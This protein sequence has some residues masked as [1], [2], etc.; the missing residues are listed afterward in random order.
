MS[1]R[2]VRERVRERTTTRGG[3]ARSFSWAWKAVAAAV[4]ATAV[5]LV[6]FRDRPAIRTAQDSPTAPASLAPTPNASPLRATMR[7]MEVKKPTRLPR[8]RHVDPEPAEIARHEKPASASVPGLSPEEADQLAR[9]VVY[10]SH[11]QG[12]PPVI[13][14]EERGHGG[15]VRS[16]HPLRNSKPERGH[17]LADRFKRRITI[18]A[19]RFDF[20][21][22]IPMTA[23]TSVTTARSSEGEH[24][25]PELQEARIRADLDIREGQY[26]VVGKTGLGGSDNALI[27]VLSA[28]VVD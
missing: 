10:V 24:A 2:S 20:H 21:V 4:V 1:L 6:L 13:E 23:R 14:A 18:R 15:Y 3:E 17:L 27:L 7:P 11:L 25:S 9:A 28:R 16:F 19:T 26:V 5:A 12:L 8:T 22:I